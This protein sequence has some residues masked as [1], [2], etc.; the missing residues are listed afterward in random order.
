MFKYHLPK[1]RSKKLSKAVELA[2][3]LTGFKE[4]DG[5]YE[6][7]PTAEEVGG[8][9]FSDL[10]DLSEKWKG[11]AFF[12]DG[13]EVDKDKFMAAAEGSTAK[14]EPAKEEPAKE[15]PAKEEAPA[16]DSRAEEEPAQKE[17]PEAESPAEEEAKEEDAPAEEPP[18]KKP[19]KATEPKKEPSKPEPPPKPDPEPKP[20]DDKKSGCCCWMPFTFAA[21]VALVIGHL[22]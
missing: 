15:E 4:V 2:K 19:E 16:E 13:A 7:S 8:S 22:M 12:L 6:I 10:L 17:E 21:I 20:P 9:V 1:S 14:E 5:G 3:S 18:P 11:A